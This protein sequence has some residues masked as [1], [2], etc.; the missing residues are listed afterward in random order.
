[1]DVEHAPI[2]NRKD[3]ADAL[4]TSAPWSRPRPPSKDIDIAEKCIILSFRKLQLQRIAELQDK[5]LAFS[6]DPMLQRG[7]SLLPDLLDEASGAYI[8]SNGSPCAAT[9]D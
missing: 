9:E 1:M 2:D 8:T 3:D 6:V 4:P 5:L 7:R